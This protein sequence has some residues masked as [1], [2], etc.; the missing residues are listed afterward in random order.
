MTEQTISKGDIIYTGPITY[1]VTDVKHSWKF[2]LVDGSCA[3]YP[4]LFCNYRCLCDAC[5]KRGD[6]PYKIKIAIIDGKL[7]EYF[8]KSQEFVAL[9]ED[10]PINVINMRLLHINEK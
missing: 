5:V 6:G 7:H 1:L 2:Q 9:D 10:M 3:E 8:H 4:V